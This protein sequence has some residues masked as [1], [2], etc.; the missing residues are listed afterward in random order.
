[1]YVHASVMGKTE[2]WRAK[3]SGTCSGELREKKIPATDDR[4]WLH[5][6]MTSSL[7]LVGHAADAARLTG[8][9]CHSWL[10]WWR[11]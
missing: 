2:S 10:V 7:L 9:R 8:R 3:Q 4:M 5:V 6:E 11:S 1:M